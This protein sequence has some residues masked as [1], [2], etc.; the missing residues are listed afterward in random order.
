MKFNS[1]KPLIALAGG[2]CSGKST[3]AKEFEKH[4]CGL[5]DA[6][7]IVHELLDN[8]KIKRLIIEN[9]GSEILNDNDKINRSKLAD[10]VFSDERELE[11]LNNILHPKVFTHCQKLIERYN[12]DNKIKAIVLDI[13]LLLEKGWQ[14]GCDKLVFVDSNWANRS[15]RAFQKSN[16]SEKQLKMRENF[17]ISLDK[18]AEISDNSI[19]NNSDIQTLAKQVTK[20]FSQVMKNEDSQGR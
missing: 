19:D 7:K 10:T 13:P 18:K 11:K 16:L 17:Q 20:I 8:E 2:I 1:P 15:K 5:V 6:D 14:D 4:G 9:F 3:V 12:N